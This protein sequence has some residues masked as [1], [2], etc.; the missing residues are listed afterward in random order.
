MTVIDLPLQVGFDPPSK[1]RIKM[2]FEFAEPINLDLPSLALPAC[3]SL[4]WISIAVADPTGRIF[5]TLGSST[6]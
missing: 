1:G 3:S 2:K 4:E 5:A 6:R